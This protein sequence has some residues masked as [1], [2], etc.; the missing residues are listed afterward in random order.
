MTEGQGPCPSLPV[1][2]GVGRLWEA[3]RHKA[4]GPF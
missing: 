1:R 4:S 2:A 3:L